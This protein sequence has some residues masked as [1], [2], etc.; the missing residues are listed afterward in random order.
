MYHLGLTRDSGRGIAGHQEVVV[1]GHSI[2][3]D[4]RR[5]RRLEESACQRPD[6]VANVGALAVGVPVTPD[7]PVEAAR[8]P[9]RHALRKRPSDRE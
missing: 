8:V 5:C 4:A 1:G 3:G 9:R 7:D 6:P 2:G